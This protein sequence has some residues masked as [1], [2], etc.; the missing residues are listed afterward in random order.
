MII[1]SNLKASYNYYQ[2]VEKKIIQDTFTVY[3]FSYFQHDLWFLT[4]GKGKIL[5]KSSK[6]DS[7]GLF[8]LSLHKNKSIKKEKHFLCFNRISRF[9]RIL[10]FGEI[11]TNPKLKDKTTITLGK[12]IHLGTKDGFYKATQQHLLDSYKFSKQKILNF[13]KEYDSTQ[14]YTYDVPD[15]HL[16]Q[17]ANLNI[18]AHNKTF[19]NIITETLE[20]PYTIFFSEK[21]FKPI[22]CAQP[23]I[24]FGNPYSLVKLREYGFQTFNK[25]WDE[26]YDEEIDLTRRLEKIVETLEY[27]SEWDLDTCFKVTQEMESVFINNFNILKSPDKVLQLHEN[28]KVF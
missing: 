7:Y 27:I 9:H 6:E 15:L 24:L 13:F 1:T 18:S 20:D 11:Q 4:E 5:N 19:L 10:L 28:L 2:L 12:D 23:F 17:A 25:W 14:Q 16:N 26:S 8:K 21:T 3:P 22:F